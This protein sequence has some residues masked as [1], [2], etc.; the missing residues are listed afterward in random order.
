MVGRMARA[1]SSVVHAPVDAWLIMAAIASRC[2]S[3][4]CVTH[5]APWVFIQFRTPSAMGSKKKSG[6]FAMS[7]A[8]L[9]VMASAQMGFSFSFTKLA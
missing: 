9:A 4:I 5:S 8:V 2:S 1:S 3:L 6:C 7:W